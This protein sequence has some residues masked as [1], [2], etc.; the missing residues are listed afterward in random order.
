MNDDRRL[1]RM[2]RL[3]GLIIRRGRTRLKDID[4]RINML[5]D[6]QIQTEDQM[7]RMSEESRAMRQD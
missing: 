3:L 5:I 4:E 7:R 1:D 2:E 6:A